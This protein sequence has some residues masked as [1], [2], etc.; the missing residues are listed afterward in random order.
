M[1]TV[2]RLN[3]RKKRDKRTTTHCALVARAFGANTL[4]YTGEQDSALE[5]S[6]NKI[7]KQWGGSFV[8]KYE[9]NT[10]KF[11]KR[12]NKKT[13]IN[14]TMYGLPIQNE[15]KHIRK[16]KDLIIVIGGSKVPIDIYKLSHYNISITSQPHSE[17]AALSIFLD[18]FFM[19]K[20]LS[21]SFKRARI[22]VIPNKCG[23]TIKKR[24]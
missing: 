4:V 13:I 18:H 8:A 15:I 3:H 16:K 1:I 24:Q 23:K 2:L 12:Q 17:V 6:I 9:K 5:T 20:E 11:L 21:K 10:K 22:K 14:L 7:T 19:Q